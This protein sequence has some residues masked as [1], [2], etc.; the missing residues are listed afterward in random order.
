MR[1]SAISYLNTAPLMWD[2]EHGLAPDGFEI[3]YTVPSQCAAELQSGKSDIGIIPSAA[4]ATIPHLK[5]LPG[6]TIA[7]KQAVSSI[8]LVS[9]KP[10][11]QIASIALD[12]SSLTSVALIRVLFEKFWRRSPQ[13]VP[14]PPELETMLLHYDAALLI[15]D[16]ALAVD[17]SKYFTWDLAEEWVRCT[18]KPFV[19]AFWAVTSKASQHTSL[20]LATIFLESCEH[21]LQAESLDTIAEVWSKKLALPAPSLRRYLTQNIWYRLDQECLEGLQLFYKLAHSAG[22]LPRAPELEFVSA[23]AALVR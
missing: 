20:D 2:F 13:F 19:F 7:A 12:N 11:Q 8:L 14:L 16:P 22:V 17:R 4:Y 5:I 15:G 6:V 9:R 23:K 21:G 3:S 18:G 10:L 1:I